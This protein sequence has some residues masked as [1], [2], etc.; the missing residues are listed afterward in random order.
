MYN[1]LSDLAERYK[2]CEAEYR[3]DYRIADRAHLSR[4]ERRAIRNRA[5]I[6][7]EEYR[8]LVVEGFI[9]EDY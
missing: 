9:V 2:E 8:K 6:S 4:I 1:V 5:G 3:A 7:E